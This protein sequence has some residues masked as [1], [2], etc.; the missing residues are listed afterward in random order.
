[1]IRC[2]LSSGSN[3]QLLKFRW[4]LLSCQASAHFAPI[5]ACWADHTANFH[6]PDVAYLPYISLKKPSWCFLIQNWSWRLRAICTSAFSDIGRIDH[7]AQGQSHSIPLSLVVIMNEEARTGFAS[8][9]P[10]PDGRQAI[11]HLSR[12]REWQARCHLSISFNPT[13][14]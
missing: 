14:P 5:R 2:C 9:M 3:T 4:F 7:I 11:T 1:M 10:L 6:T 8:S 12:H 13:L